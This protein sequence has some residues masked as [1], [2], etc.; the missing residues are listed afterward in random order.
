VGGGG[1]GEEEPAGVFG[2]GGSDQ[3][4]DGGLGDVDRFV[5]VVGGDAVVGDDGEAGG[6]AAPVNL[7]ETRTR[8][9]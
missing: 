4:P 9:V 8:G 1:V 6:G 7:Y 3:S 2:F 5:G